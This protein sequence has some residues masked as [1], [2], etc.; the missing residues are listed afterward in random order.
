MVGIAFAKE[1]SVAGFVVD[2]GGGRGC[3]GSLWGLA[4][5]GGRGLKTRR[6]TTHA[7]AGFALGTG[8]A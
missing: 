4:S 3:F 6:N 8:C 1:D 2:L 7:P 5:A